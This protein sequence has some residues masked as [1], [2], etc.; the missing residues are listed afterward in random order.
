VPGL[1]L[2]VLRYR[3]FIITSTARQI[4][5][6]YQGSLFGVAWLF[7]GPLA[8]LAVHTVIFSTLFQN[9][10]A[11]VDS[12]FSYSIYLCAGLLPWLY[13]S[14]SVSRLTGTFV[15]QA[16]L[17]KKAQFP[18]ICLPLI[19][20]GVSSFNFAVIAGLFLGFL[21]ITGNWPGMVLLAGLPALSI[22][23][24]LS[25]G[26]GV[27][28]GVINVYFR[29]VGHLVGV[30]FQFLFWLTPIVY[31]LNM[32]PAWAQA[33]I[34]ANPMTVLVE[35]YQSVILYARIPSAQAFQGLA[36][37]A[38]L[39]G[40]CLFLAFKIHRDLGGEMADEL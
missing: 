31:P 28:L 21:L 29:D 26:L 15:A 20:M 36:W 40:V 13:F 9:R 8:L 17:I 12:A 1:L 35:H 10:L 32:L 24:M 5:G 27:F 16:G 22:Q 23:I 33:A 25:L 2:D 34:K 38:L 39:A 14:D 18:R 37:V 6:Q 7:L 19:A 11:G 30:V 3:G 4:Q